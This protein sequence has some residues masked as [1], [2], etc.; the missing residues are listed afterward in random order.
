MES[1]AV[2]ANM[3]LQENNHLGIARACIE[4]NSFCLLPKAFVVPGPLPEWNGCKAYYL[5][6]PSLGGKFLE[7]RLHLFPNGGTKEA[8]V[9]EYQNFI[10]VLNGCAEVVISGKKHTLEKES[11]FWVPPKVDFEVQNTS[12][13]EIDL[14]WVRKNYVES[15]FYSVPDAK[16]SSVLDIPAVQTPAERIQE[17]LPEKELGY[18]MAMNIMAFDPGVTFPRAEIHVFEHGEYFLN[19]R[20]NIWINGRYHEVM[21]DDFAFISAFTPHFV[22]GYGPEPLRYLLFKDINRDYTI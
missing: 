1:P 4:P 8:I 22:A 10:Y 21:E 11:F 3:K 14:L 18:D 15:K 16:V 5:A 19:G 2:N 12:E 9:S 17:C 20:G 6:T 7:C 13:A